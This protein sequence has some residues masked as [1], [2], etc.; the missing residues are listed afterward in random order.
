MAFTTKGIPDYIYDILNDKA[1][2]RILTPYIVEL[3]KNQ[4]TNKIILE[5]LDNIETKI[6]SISSGV[7]INKKEPSRSEELKEGTVFKAKEVKKVEVDYK[8]LEEKDF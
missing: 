3:V 6:D 2:K 1:D 4:E 5:K 7:V 8:D